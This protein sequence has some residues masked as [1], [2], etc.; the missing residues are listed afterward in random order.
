MNEKF[1]GEAIK[2]VVSTFDANRMA[3]GE[4][5]LPSDFF[6]R[7]R[8]IHIAGV[9]STWKET[10]P[11]RHG[12]GEQYVRKHWFEVET[13]SNGIMKIYFERS[14]RGGSKTAR[15]WLFTASEE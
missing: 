9:R 12:S 5:G 11:C 15:W 7:G 2:P 3:M 8:T 13:E 6:W 10:G 14:P 1:I 4:P